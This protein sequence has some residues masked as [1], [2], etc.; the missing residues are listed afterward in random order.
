MASTLT[1]VASIICQDC[2]TPRD[3]VPSNTLYCVACRLLRN[4][5]YFRHRRRTCATQGCSH[6]F[7]PIGRNDTHCSKC[8]PGLRVYSVACKLGGKNPHEGLTLVRGIPVCAT[9]LRAPAQ[10]A[11]LLLALENGQAGRRKANGLSVREEATAPAATPPAYD[12]PANRFMIA[13]KVDHPKPPVESNREY[14]DRLLA[15]GILAINPDRSLYRKE[16]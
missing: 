4:V 16:A 13:L 10:R 3:G 9:C 8:D 12:P 15:A 11:Q 14:I 7:A 6:E 1:A 2:S 5:D